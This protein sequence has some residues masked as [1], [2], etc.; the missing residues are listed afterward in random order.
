MGALEA[1]LARLEA[2]GSVGLDTPVFI[3]AFEDNRHY[4][5]VALAAFAQ[6]AS[7]QFRACASAL[8][9]GETL[10]AAHKA[11]RP[12]LVIRY[13]ALFQSFPNLETRAFDTDAADRMA[14]LRAKYSVCMPD[15]IHLASALGWGARAFLTNDASLRRVSEIEVLLLSDYV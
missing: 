8:A 6:L 5:A 12:D 7:G 9:L 3:Y 1:L 15:A 13:R 4:G 2:A 11:E 14:E 10:V